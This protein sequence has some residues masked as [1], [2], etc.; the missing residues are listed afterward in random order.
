MRSG[1]RY[2]ENCGRNAATI[3]PA[4]RRSSGKVQI[5]RRHNPATTREEN[6][7][8]LWNLGQ[9]FCGTLPPTLPAGSAAEAADADTFA[10]AAVTYNGFAF[11]LS[12]PVLTG[13]TGFWEG[14]R[15][16]SLLSFD[17]RRLLRRRVHIPS[18]GLMTCTGFVRSSNR[19][20]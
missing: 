9:R 12:A 5:R 13:A 14:G 2:L 4:S 19:L 10:G 1:K 17:R 11:A 7:A 15:R 18:P 8:A 3:M 16:S 6:R 20:L